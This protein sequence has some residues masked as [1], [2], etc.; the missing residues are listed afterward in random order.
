MPESSLAS[1]AAVLEEDLIFLDSSNLSDLRLLLSHVEE[2]AN[3]I[4]MLTRSVL[5]RPWVLAEL[6]R[7]HQC[8]KRMIVISA[9]WGSE[10]TST[11]GRA[12]RQGI[13]TLA[14]DLEMLA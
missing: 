3:Y 4:L 12:F 14:R 9:T 13:Q 2:S 6:V 10:E 11:T 7:A 8:K 1:A 5:E